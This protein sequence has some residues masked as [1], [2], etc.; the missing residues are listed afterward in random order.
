MISIPNRNKNAGG[1]T[2]PDSAKPVARRLL[3]PLS[4]K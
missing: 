4:E 2:F 1:A 3:Y